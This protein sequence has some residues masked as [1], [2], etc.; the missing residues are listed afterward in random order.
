MNLSEYQL[1]A[2]RTLPRR[3]F[4]D[5]LGMAAMGA[6]GEAGEVLELA[7]KYLYHAHDLDQDLL[8]KEIGDVLWY[9]AALCTVLGYDLAEVAQENLDKLS[10]RY[11]DGFDPEKSRNRA[12]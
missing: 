6:A 7:K 12:E 3:D 2:A 1:A 5:N 4:D 11:P 8:R 9:V 10:A